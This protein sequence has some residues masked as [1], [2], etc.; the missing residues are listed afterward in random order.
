MKP[1][2]NLAV[3]VIEYT[4]TGDLKEDVCALT[5]QINAVIETA[6]REH[7]EQW[8]WLHNR[9]K[10]RPPEE[11]SPAGQTPAAVSTAK[12]DGGPCSR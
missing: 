3:S 10:R 5:T 2:P 12:P 9:W 6:I 8:F 11:V 1:M 4:V 7:P